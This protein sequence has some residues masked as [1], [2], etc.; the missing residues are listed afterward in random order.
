[1]QYNTIQYFIDNSPWGLFSDN[2][3]KGSNNSANDNFQQC[4]LNVSHSNWQLFCIVLQVYLTV[5]NPLIFQVNFLK[6]VWVIKRWL[7]KLGNYFTHFAKI[8][9]IC[10][11][12][13]G[14]KLHC[15]LRIVSFWL[16]FCIKKSHAK[17]SHSSFV[18]IY[19][20]ICGKIS[21]SQLSPIIFS[22]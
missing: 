2:A 10:L 8:L 3:I 20:K 22:D 16:A 5:V 6:Y 19:A 15:L 14:D 11:T 18:I 1:M 13:M 17:H 12:F 9:I 21:Q 7:V 4:N